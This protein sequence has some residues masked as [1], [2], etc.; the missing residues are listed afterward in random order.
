MLTSG[1]RKKNS[2]LE[3][4]I[5]TAFLKASCL[6]ADNHGSLAAGYGFKLLDDSTG[7]WLQ[8]VCHDVADYRRWLDAFR[9]ERRVVTDDQLRGF[10][11]MSLAKLIIQLPQQH[12]RGM[13]LALR[14]GCD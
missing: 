13:K 4:Y 5:V 10:D 6:L 2:T 9:A 12:V 3:V 7:R 14:K 11:V 1:Q 8:F